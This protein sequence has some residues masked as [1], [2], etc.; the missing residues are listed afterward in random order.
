MV[1]PVSNS[2][3]SKQT[4]T[5]HQC[6]QVIG[7]VIIF[8][9]LTLTSMKSFSAV[10]ATVDRNPAMVAETFYLIVSVDDSVNRNALDTSPLLKEFI[11]GQTSVSSNTQ[12]INGSASRQ[13][14]FRVGLISRN[15][16]TLTIPSLSINGMN[17]DPIAMQIVEREA[18]DTQDEEV[19]L[20]TSISS[21]TAYIGQPIIYT[22]KLLIGTRL[23][24]ANLQEPSLIGSDITQLGE[25][26]DSSEIINGK[27]YRT[28]S[29]RYNISPSQAGDFTLEG[30][31]FRGDISQYGYGRSKPI[32]L[33]GENH[34]IKVKAIPPSFP[35][36]WL[37]S[38]IVTIEDDWA[39]EDTYQVGEPITRTITLSAAN[40]TTAQMPDLT[41]N[42]GNALQSYPDKPV[43]KKGFSGQTLVAQVVQKLALIPIKAGEITVPEVRIPWFNVDTEQLQWA[44][45]PQKT[46]TVQAG[47][48]ATVQ[49]IAPPPLEQTP[50]PQQQRP[51]ANIADTDNSKWLWQLV[52]ALLLIS[53]LLSV[54]YIIILRQ[55]IIKPDTK[56]SKS[57]EIS[58]ANYATLISALDKNNLT[59]VMQLVPLWL[60]NDYDLGLSSPQVQ[61]ASIT[62]HYEELAQTQYSQVPQEA[63]CQALKQCVIAFMNS[64]NMAIKPSL[65]GLY[66]K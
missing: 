2:A 34:S 39:T 59:K 42:A 24:R 23:Q 57:F 9:C 17:T 50:E 65:D 48:Q 10:K 25:D 19:K 33:L 56:D 7:Y 13:T 28:I 14:T 35:G 61:A 58:S 15:A 31:I 21:N 29:R 12:I 32:T 62:M 11:V 41:I 5:V 22:I 3:V 53:L 54:A 63:N 8:L 60:K 44:V 55:K 26:Q 52:S 43:L 47:E 20:E 18:S 49:P 38:P 30:T 16:G 66:K 36:Q 46:I 64:N 6:L 40:V 45:I 37:A 4:T 27:R 1:I 51:S